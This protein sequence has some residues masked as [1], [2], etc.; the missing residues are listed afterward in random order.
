MSKIFLIEPQKMLQQAIVL[1]LFPDHEVRL[2]KDLSD[3]SGF[4]AR[5]F[6]VVIIDAAALREVNALSGQWLGKVRAWEAPIIW[7]D[8]AG[9]S[10]MPRRN[11]VV[12]LQRPIERTALQAAVA[13]CLGTAAN[14]TQNGMTGP[15]HKS[16]RHPP[17][18]A[19]E[20][21]AASELPEGRV[22]EL[23]DV[24]EED[25]IGAAQKEKKTK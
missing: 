11:N 22:I 25:K 21:G 23:V 7:I 12:V 5:D 10:P 14:S 1:S 16:G 9:G 6:D 17:A 15:S 8:E 18:T 4:A 24:V 3:D 13:E 20:T 19:A 2:Q